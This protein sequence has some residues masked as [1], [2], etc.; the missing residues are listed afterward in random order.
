MSGTKEEKPKKSIFKK[1]WF[2][3][4]VAVV[5]FIVIGSLGKGTGSENATPQTQP[6]T[7]TQTP[8]TQEPAATSQSFAVELTNGHFTAGVDFPAGTY[9]IEAVN[10]GGNVSSSNAY[11]GG[12]N[13]VMGTADMNQGVDIYEQKYSNIKLPDGTVLSID[14]VTVKISSVNASTKKLNPLVEDTANK[15][16]LSNGNFTA[17]TDFAEGVYNIV[18]V[19]G[20]GNVSSSNT[21]NGGINAIMGT[22]E[23]NTG[24]DIYEQKYFNISLPK[25]TVLTIDGV[26]IDLIPLK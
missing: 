25:D 3:L 13:A 10:G 14:K 24:V 4:I 23:Q 7:G 22:K 5:L 26:T 17:G 16:T 2:W 20:G 18:A 6:D 12:I 21:L 8:Q 11:S 9:N 1:W 19:K 15:I